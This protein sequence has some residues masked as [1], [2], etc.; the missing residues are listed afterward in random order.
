MGGVEAV[1]LGHV[2]DGG[3]GEELAYLAPPT[4]SVASGVTSTGL[5]IY[6]GSVIVSSG[7]V[8]SGAGVYAGG[9]AT[10]QTGGSDQNST[11][12]AGGFETELGSATGDLIYGTQL[13]SAA[14]AIVSGETVY[15]GGAI[16][17][18]LAG[19]SGTN[20]VDS[21]G[22]INISGRGTL[23]NATLYGGTLS[24][25]SPKA[26]LSGSLTFSGAA[27]L[28]ETAT[29]SAV[30]AGIYFGDEAEI[31]GFAA[32]DVI[33]L[34]S[35][36]QAAAAGANP[37]LTVTTGTLSGAAYVGSVISGATVTSATISF[38][39]STTGAPS[40]E[41]FTFSGTGLASQLVLSPD[42]NGGVELVVGT[43][44]G[45][46]TTSTGATAGSG[47]VLV[48]SSGGTASAATV[49]SGGMANVV[50]G[51]TDK[52][53][54]IKMGGTE[55][56]LGSATGDFIYGSQVVSS[57][58]IVNSETVFGG[59][60]VNLTSATG[61]GLVVSSGGSL[62]LGSGSTASNT[63]LNTG[64]LT[65][66]DPTAQLTGSLNLDPGNT[67]IVTS[68]QPSGYSDTAVISG[69]SAGDV[70]D[71]TSSTNV[72]SAWAASPSQ[73][74]LTYT[75]S[76]GN[77]VVSVTE[78][79]T[80]D[81]FIFDG[82]SIGSTLNL[83]SDGNGGVDI[84]CYAEGTLIRTPHGDVPVETLAAGDLVETA[85]GVARPVKWMGF[86]RLDLARH[87]APEQAQPIRIKA[88]AIACGVP[89]RDLRLSPDHA[90]LLDGVLIPARLLRNGT[91]II[92][93]TSCRA[94]TYYHVEL[95][96]H[97][98]LVAEGMAAE[99]YLDT[100]NRNMFAN[101]GSAMV[102]FPSFDNGQARREAESCAPFAAAPAT[103]LPI[104]QA[105][106]DR[107]TLLGLTAPDVATTPDPAL[108]VMA[109]SRR[110]DPITRDGGR[111][112]F[113][114]PDASETVRLVSR[115]AVPHEL[116]PWVEDRRNLGVRVA[117]LSVMAG[118]A[119]VTIALDDPALAEGWWD[120]ETDGQ[121][122]ARWTNGNAALPHLAEGFAILDVVIEGG[123]VY[124]VAGKPAEA[125]AAA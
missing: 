66:S 55:A 36:T 116:H 84:A 123:L 32:G 46:G 30:S 89:A 58:G 98:V 72:G 103:V 6:A 28:I 125:R 64:T 11:I 20:I 2:A 40:S 79:A 82:T 102:L 124:P 3:A 115:A 122:M 13:V 74:A 27:T 112:R 70:I 101:A 120:V 47:T 85:A 45:N 69:F 7:G 1:G 99:S 9:S 34:A 35:T 76:G 39:P 25:Q 105:I 81:T 43:T 86:R 59:G 77:T 15:T 111:Y 73:A 83:V 94:V 31:F 119:L 63:T 80:T 118:D 92:R 48:V 42:G 22:Q 91:T 100:G 18:F 107:A 68:D 19:T 62:S 54:T 37:A 24:L 87:P 41:V 33:D 44:V 21:G 16:D 26:T 65:I 56:V 57:G 50:S 12:F 104:W 53:S 78:G 75:T 29:L 4:V 93:E 113:V 67:I 95:D 5:N 8:L 60:Y 38:N 110:I 96:S 10:I 14:T 88:G 114:L 52:G 108:F 109:G 51:G 106:A 121:R 23:T 90:V 71:L 61:T 49:S 17:L 117:R 97:D